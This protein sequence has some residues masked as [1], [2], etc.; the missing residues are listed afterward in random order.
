MRNLVASRV[1]LAD[2]FFALTALYGVEYLLRPTDTAKV[3]NVLERAAPFWAWGLALILPAL[4]GL[5]ADRMKWWGIAVWGHMVCFAVFAGLLYGLIAGVAEARQL[6]GW[7]L[8]IGYLLLIL[9]HGLWGVIDVIRDRAQEIAGDEA[10][11]G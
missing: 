10:P 4:F 11:H 5:A 2:L 7:Q 6:W 3:L 9:L 1:P 8:G